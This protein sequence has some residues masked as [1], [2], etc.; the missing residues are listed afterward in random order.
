MPK[1][2][3]VDRPIEK[4]INLPVSLCT[5]IDLLLYS[6]LEGRVPHG[7]WSKLVAQ[8]LESHITKLS[9]GKAS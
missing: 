6:E 2:R 9:E 3:R 8:L 1:P 5:K 4:S 7:A